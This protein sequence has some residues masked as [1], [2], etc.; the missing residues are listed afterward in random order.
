MMHP[1]KRHK[2]AS[3]TDNL[4]EEKKYW[5]VNP[6]ER[7]K[8]MVEELMGLQDQHDLLMGLT[9]EAEP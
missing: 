6:K 3:I 9:M 4:E 8:K 2:L 7:K 1:L 5:L